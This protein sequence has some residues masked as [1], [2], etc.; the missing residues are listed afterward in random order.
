[1]QDQKK[2]ERTA[3]VCVIMGIHVLVRQPRHLEKQREMEDSEGRLFVGLF[4]C[5]KWKILL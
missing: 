2:S 3:G 5:E 1:M 4:S